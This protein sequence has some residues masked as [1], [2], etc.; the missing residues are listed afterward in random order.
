MSDLLEWLEAHADMPR[1]DLARRVRDWL[2]NSSRT[3]VRGW[4]HAGDVEQAYQSLTERL[5]ELGVE[6]FSMEELE[7]QQT[8]IQETTSDE[9]AQRRH[10]LGFTAMYANERLTGG[11]RFHC[12]NAQLSWESEEPPWVLLDDREHDALTALGGPPP[13]LEAAYS[14]KAGA[15]TP[16]SKSA[17]DVSMLAP[18]TAERLA[19]EAILTGRYDEALLY[20][21]R[22]SEDGDFGLLTRLKRIGIFVSAKR[23]DEGRVLWSQTA[24]EWLHGNRRVWDTQW[25]KLLELHTLLGMPKNDSRLDRIRAWSSPPASAPRSSSVCAACGGKGWIAKDPSAFPEMCRCRR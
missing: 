22:V 21:S 4:W 12:L 14:G 9:E 19:D 7:A 10:Q 3:L 2:G 13:L 20:L 18:H 1:G 17:L 25:T 5:K 8:R 24:D 16:L 15:P 11:R 23:T 6:P